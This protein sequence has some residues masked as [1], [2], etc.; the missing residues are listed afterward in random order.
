[1]LQYLTQRR[2]W[3]FQLY[4]YIYNILMDVNYHVIGI[5]IILPIL[6]T[7]SPLNKFTDITYD[8]R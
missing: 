6:F 1:M 7:F 4:I 5:P 3:T 2:L 8:S